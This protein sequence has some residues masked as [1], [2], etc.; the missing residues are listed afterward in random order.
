MMVRKL[1]ANLSLFVWSEK[2]GCNKI[3]VMGL[4][5]KSFASV[6]EKAKTALTLF[7]VF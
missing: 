6:A 7:T 5:G 1:G 4:M 3:E 2:V